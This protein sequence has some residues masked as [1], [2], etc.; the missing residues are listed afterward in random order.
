M[1]TRKLK[2]KT[3]PILFYHSG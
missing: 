1:I 2:I 3:S